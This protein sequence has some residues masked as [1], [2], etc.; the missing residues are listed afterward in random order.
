LTIFLTRINAK[1][2]GNSNWKEELPIKGDRIYELSKDGIILCDILETLRPDSLDTRT[3]E[4]NISDDFD[5]EQNLNLAFSSLQA[6]GGRFTSKC[7][8]KLLKNGNKEAVLQFLWES[9][10]V[11]IYKEVLDSKPVRKI[12]SA[13]SGE[14]ENDIRDSWGAEQILVGWANYA[15]EKTSYEKEIASLKDFSNPDLF[16]HLLG[17]LAGSSTEALSDS[18][19][20]NK[21]NAII[22]IAKQENI[23]QVVTAAG[24]LAGNERMIVHLLGYIFRKF[25]PK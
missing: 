6:A 3:I 1:L 14:S 4:R 23:P 18:D 9:L 21:V 8:V 5:R 7:T 24:L 20:K 10:K 16:I 19:D 25:H 2:K 12:L 17:H 13:K 11:G 15:M 22:N